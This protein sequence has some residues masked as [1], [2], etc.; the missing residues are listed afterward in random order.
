VSSPWWW[1]HSSWSWDSRFRRRSRCR[2]LGGGFTESLE[3][4]QPFS[5]SGAGVDRLGGAVR[6]VL[7]VGAAVFAVGAGVA[8]VV[9]LLVLRSGSSHRFRRRSRCRRLGGGFDGPSSRAARFRRR[10]RCRL[11]GG[12]TSSWSGS[13]GFRR[14]SRCRRLG[15]GFSSS[16]SRSSRFRSLEQVSPWW[17]VY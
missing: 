6:W 1:V 8:L 14:R 15:G 17:W 5:P 4:G 7:G 13:S 16:W 11:G 10:S 9:G 2:R 12:F 3:L